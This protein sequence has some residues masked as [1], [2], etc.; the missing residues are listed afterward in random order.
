MRGFFV[1]GLPAVR[2]SRSGRSRVRHPGQWLR[3]CPDLLAIQHLG[4]PSPR[5]DG[6]LL[7]SVPDSFRKLE[8]E[9]GS[10][11][12]AL[13]SPRVQRPFRLQPSSTQQQ[14]SGLSDSSSSKTTRWER[15]VAASAQAERLQE[16]CKP[17]GR[18]RRANR[19]RRGCRRR[20]RE[21]RPDTKAGAHLARQGQFGRVAGTKTSH[22]LDSISLVP[23]R[24]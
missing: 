6:H 14:A 5:P 18:R 19:A 13:T 22:L 16:F 21:A 23:L 15:A 24:S 9:R 17:I 12:P 8:R 7:E 20:R 4:R 1:A 11:R 3:E 2:R 10:T